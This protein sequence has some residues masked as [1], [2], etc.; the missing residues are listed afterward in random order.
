[1]SRYIDA[2]LPLPDWSSLVPRHPPHGLDERI[3][4]VVGEMRGAVRAEFFLNID[5]ADRV[6]GLQPGTLGPPTTGSSPF[7]EHPPSHTMR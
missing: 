1:M 5:C 4:K 6:R 2:V 7:P 3:Q